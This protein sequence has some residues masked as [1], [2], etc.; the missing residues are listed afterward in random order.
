[1]KNIKQPN[2]KNN[3]HE[4]VEVQD[5]NTSRSKYSTSYKL[6]LEMPDGNTERLDVARGI[7]HDVEVGDYVTVC[8]NVSV[9]GVEIWRVHR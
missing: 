8:K 1:M 4:I 5:K 7:Y 6:V 2:R 9:L 3:T